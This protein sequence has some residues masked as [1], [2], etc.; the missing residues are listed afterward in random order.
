MDNLP[1]TQK[2]AYLTLLI[3][4]NCIYAHLAYYDFSAQRT[5]VI[6]DVTDLSSLKYRLDDIVFGRTFWYEYFISLEK[7]FDWDIVDKAWGDNIKMLEFV[8]EE[9][10]VSGIKIIIDDNQPFFKNIFTSL[11]SFSNDVVLRVLDDKYIEQLL[12]G[13]QQRLGYEDILWLDLDLAHFSFYRAKVMNTQPGILKKEKRESVEYST[14]KINWSNEI[15]LIDFVKSSKLQAFLSIDQ[16]NDDIMNK[17]AN[18]I[19]PEHRYLSDSVTEDILRAFTTYQILNTK[20]S[21]KEKFDSLGKNNGAI[22]LTGRIP[23]LLNKK[24]LLIS[25]VDG[26][27]LE[28]MVDVFIDN[29]NKVLTYGK[30]L[31]QKEQSR[32]ILVVKSDVLPKASKLVIPYIPSKGRNKV[33]FSGQ[34]LSQDTSSTEIYGINPLF[35]IFSFPNTEE[36]VIFEAEL[37]NGATF[38]HLTSDNIQ[39][40][41][42]TK[43]LFYEDIVV[44]CRGRPVVYGPDAY[45]N[46]VKLRLWGCGNKE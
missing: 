40:M 36:S 43:D 13:L 15:G 42:S 19:A 16:S 18:F 4:D 33:V 7:V 12:R 9:V 37:K 44:D 20:E 23:Q 6:T 31:V 10:G 3:K 24:E 21:N 32:D 41:S 17:W 30:S 34:F 38:A 5:Y 46:R 22:F 2:N 45:T 29:D 39:I 8:R 27:E 28:G 1:I 25:I 35:E 26:L 11:K 14:S